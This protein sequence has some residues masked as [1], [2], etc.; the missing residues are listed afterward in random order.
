MTH[1]NIVPLLEMA[2]RS[3]DRH[4][5]IKASIYMV[6]PYMDHDLDGLLKNPNVRFTIP[7]IKSYMQQLL[8]AADYLHKENILHRDMKCKI[9]KLGKELI[10]F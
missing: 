5:N 6:F 1:E 10:L 7:Q 2:V 9:I 3:S 4:A 8:R